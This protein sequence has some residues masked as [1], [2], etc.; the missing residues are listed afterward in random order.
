MPTVS[1]TLAHCQ[2]SAPHGEIVGKIPSITALRIL[3]PQI[4]PNGKHKALATRRIN[5]SQMADPALHPQETRRKYRMKPVAR[6]VHLT[7]VGWNRET[8]RFRYLC[9]N[10]YIMRIFH[11]INVYI[12]G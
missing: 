12:S 10:M 11:C 7:E 3:T 4:G 8:D 9:I 1:A 5:M 6:K 2:L